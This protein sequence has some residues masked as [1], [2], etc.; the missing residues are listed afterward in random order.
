MI[1]ALGTVAN[2]LL[3]GHINRGRDVLGRFVPLPGAGRSAYS[4]YLYYDVRHAYLLPS[5]SDVL[6][7]KGTL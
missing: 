3:S 6:K 1:W 2:L 5:Q 7:R 4:N